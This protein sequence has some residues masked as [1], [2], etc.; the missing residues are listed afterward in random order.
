MDERLKYA[1]FQVRWG[2]F[3]LL[4]GEK[5]LL[6]T[7][8]PCR[9]RAGA[10]VHLLGGNTVA[11]SDPGLFK[12]LQG[13]ISAY[14]EGSKVDFSDVRV[15]LSYLTPFGRKVLKACMK[16]RHGRT[17][18]YGQLAKTAGS[19]RAGRAAGSILA[20]NRLP[21]IIPCHRIIRVDGRIGGFSAA[22][23]VKLK[24]KML[25]LEAESVYR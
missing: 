10:K 9:S 21:L 15:D 24:K 14:Y 4:A 20:R 18:S 22:G 6:R 25:K 2:Y 19:G 1:I 8:L 17:I 11:E 5:G 13:K 7:C 12:G 16:V 23:G 3:G